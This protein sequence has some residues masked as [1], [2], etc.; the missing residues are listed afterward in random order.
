[1]SEASQNNELPLFLK[2]FCWAYATFCAAAMA[3]IVAMLL[4]ND[5]ALTKSVMLFAS[6][7]AGCGAITFFEGP[8]LTPLKP[9]SK[10]EVLPRVWVNAGTFWSTEGYYCWFGAWSGGIFASIFGAIFA[11]SIGSILAV[12]IMMLFG[13]LT[14]AV[15]SLLHVWIR[16]DLARKVAD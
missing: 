8:G 9:D 3:T 7:F 6:V 5:A 14:G 10:L 2:F 1:M 4:Q 11:Y 12:P 13:G 15:S 16:Q